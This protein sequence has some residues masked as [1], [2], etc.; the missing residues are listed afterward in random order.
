MF[1][2][3]TGSTVV[4]PWASKPY[5][6][7]RPYSYTACLDCNVSLCQI[8]YYRIACNTSRDSYC[9]PCNVSTPENSHYS[10]AGN[11]VHEDNCAWTC[12]DGYYATSSD[13]CQPCTNSKPPGS[14]YSGPGSVLDLSSCP[15]ECPSRHYADG[16]TCQPLAE[17]CP[18]GKCPYPSLIQ[19]SEQLNVR[20]K[21][22]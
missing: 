1:D 13:T 7:D 17:S 14:N 9:V 16:M 12:N 10:A 22:P 11:P 2:S 4:P 21:N 3:N 8:G 20:L 6:P 18:A 15:W 5:D 19:S